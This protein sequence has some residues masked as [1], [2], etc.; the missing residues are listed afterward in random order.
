MSS[1]V[2]SGNSVHSNRKARRSSPQLAVLN[3]GGAGYRSGSP[4]EGTRVRSSSLN[5]AEN[6]I[7]LNTVRKID[8]CVCEL[9]KTV[10]QVAVYQYLES[11]NNW[12]SKLRGM[13]LCS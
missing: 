8:S 10:P 9:L 1:T 13:C 2:H 11:A 12:V 5:K 4:N 3:G 7:N 6:N